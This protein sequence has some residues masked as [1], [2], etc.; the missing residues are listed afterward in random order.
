MHAMRVRCLPIPLRKVI[1]MYSNCVDNHAMKYAAWPL[2][3]TWPL[4]GQAWQKFQLDAV[5][6]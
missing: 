2:L 3:G 1:R 4:L 6:H 5:L